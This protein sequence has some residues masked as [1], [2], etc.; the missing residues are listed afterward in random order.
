V[1]ITKFRPKTSLKPLLLSVF[2]QTKNPHF[3]NR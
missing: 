2:R 1:K 3:R